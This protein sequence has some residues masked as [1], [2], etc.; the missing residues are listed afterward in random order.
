[1]N[2]KVRGTFAEAR[3]FYKGHNKSGNKAYPGSEK[4]RHVTRTE[5]S[6]SANQQISDLRNKLDF[7][8][9]SPREN[10]EYLYNNEVRYGNCAEMTC[11]AL[12][13]ADARFSIDKNLLFVASMRGLEK[14][15]NGVEF[16]HEFALIKLN[17][18]EK[19]CV[20][21]WADICC[22]LPEYST[23]FRKKMQHWTQKGKR[24]ALRGTE[25][26]LYWAVPNENVVLSILAREIKYGEVPYSPPASNWG[27]VIS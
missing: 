22:R 1:M 23:E 19:W 5:K 15:S 27:C 17:N 20:D 8:K 21:P 12:Y 25:T 4:P 26:S 9:K 18:D 7:S 16:G 14:S 13:I 24:L 3:A 6:F 2:Q 11:V 10:G